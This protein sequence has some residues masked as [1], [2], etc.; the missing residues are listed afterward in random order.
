MTFG[1]LGVAMLVIFSSVM[2]DGGDGANNDREGLFIFCICIALPCLGICMDLKVFF[3][4][5]VI[6]YFKIMEK[7]VEV[8]G[9]RCGRVLRVEGCS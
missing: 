2:G 5:G 1:I 8:L 9:E 7:Q 4:I 6:P 3:S